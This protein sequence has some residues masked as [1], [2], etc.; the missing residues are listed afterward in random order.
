MSVTLKGN[1]L[2]IEIDANVSDPQPSSSGKSR[3]VASTN[4][5]MTSSVMVQG[6]P[7]IIGLNAYIKN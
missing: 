6:K 2:I 1:K 5:N 7:V 3:I 4:G